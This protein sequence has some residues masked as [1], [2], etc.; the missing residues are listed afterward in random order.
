MF[1]GMQFFRLRCITVALGLSLG[2]CFAEIVEHRTTVTPMPDEEI[3]SPCEYR[4]VV[5]EIE[6][7]VT[8][9]WVIFDRGQDYLKWY[10][11]RQV[12][13]FARE[14]R[15]ALVLAMHCRSKERDDMIVEPAKGVGRTLFTAMDQ[16]AASTAHPELKTARVIVMGWSGA[17]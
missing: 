7:P 10:Q 3:L 15:L 8:A 14:H 5:P 6:G 13:G 17:G 12:R 1:V 11:D 16:F 9:A 4:M 2:T